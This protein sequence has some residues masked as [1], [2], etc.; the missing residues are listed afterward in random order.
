MNITQHTQFHRIIAYHTARILTKVLGIIFLN[1]N[2]RHFAYHIQ[3]VS[4]IF[5]R[6]VFQ[7]YSSLF[8]Q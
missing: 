7:I 3:Q 8:L 6:I 2:K 5:K 1:G 4:F